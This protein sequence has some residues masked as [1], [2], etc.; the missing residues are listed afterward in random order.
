MSRIR[1]ASLLIV[2]SLAA[3]VL[4][5]HRAYANAET[6]RIVAPGV[7]FRE[8]DHDAGHCNSTIIEMKDYLIVVDAGFPD[9]ARGTM[10]DV[11]RLSKKTMKYVFDTH[12]HGDHTYGNSVWTQAGATTLAFKELAD[13]MRRL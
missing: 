1:L 13:E 10:E 4:L 8:G 2:C 7:W 12:H 5:V 3:L 9:A 11:K 6:L